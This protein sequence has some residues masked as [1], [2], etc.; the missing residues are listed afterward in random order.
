MTTESFGAA[1]KRLQS[2]AGYTLEQLDTLKEAILSMAKDERDTHF[3]GFA[4]L[5]WHEVRKTSFDSPGFS[6][7]QQ[8]EKY[9]QLLFAQ[10]AY[11]LVQSACIDIS[12]EQMEQGM[13]LSPNA[14]LRAVADLTERPPK[15]ELQ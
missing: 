11:D 5:L 13:R 7:Y 4:K 14:M 8:L 9:L 1:M 6:H 10:R 3:A 2:S 15:D 12:D